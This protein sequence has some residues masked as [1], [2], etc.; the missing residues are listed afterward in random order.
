M[1][2]QAYIFKN[3]W[4]TNKDGNRAGDISG[5]RHDHISIYFLAQEAHTVTS[6]GTENLMG[7]KFHCYPLVWRF[8]NEDSAYN[9]ACAVALTHGICSNCADDPISL[10]SRDVI[11]KDKII[12]LI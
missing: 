9:G 5:C 12:N 7:S 8:R 11:K 10:I 3:P 2:L 1:W 6:A 4:C